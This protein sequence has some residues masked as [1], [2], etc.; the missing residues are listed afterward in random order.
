MR[1]F[2]LHLNTNRISDFISHLLIKTI[3]LISFAFVSDRNGNVKQQTV[4]KA[5]SKTVFSRIIRYDPKPDFDADAALRKCKERLK[6]DAN[7]KKQDYDIDYCRLKILKL[8]P[9]NSAS[10]PTPTDTIFSDINDATHVSFDKNMCR[11]LTPPN[12]LWGQPFDSL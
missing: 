5:S 11:F 4:G 7:Y 8:T 10:Q 9:S 12:R 6:T 2:F 3:I 1:L